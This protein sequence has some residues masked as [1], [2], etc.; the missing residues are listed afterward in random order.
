MSKEPL[1]GILKNMKVT[2]ISIIKWRWYPEWEINVLQI[3]T[4][5]K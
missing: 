2:Y 3:W 1:S 5:D 4:V